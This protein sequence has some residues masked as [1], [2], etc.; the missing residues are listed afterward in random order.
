M[1]G[2][3]RIA[4]NL[5]KAGREVVRGWQRATCEDTRALVADCEAQLARRTRTNC[6]CSCSLSKSKIR[7]LKQNQDPLCLVMIE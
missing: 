5:V 2:N 7:R 6:Q 4:S 3:E 1:D